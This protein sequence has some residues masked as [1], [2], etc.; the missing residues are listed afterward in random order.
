MKLSANE[1]RPR[2]ECTLQK[3]TLLCVEAKRRSQQHKHKTLKLHLTKLVN[4]YLVNN[5]MGRPYFVTYSLSHYQGLFSS[6]IKIDNNSFSY[7][8]TGG[9]VQII[10]GL[11]EL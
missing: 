10:V 6:S 5:M 8:V 11:R 9:I 1:Y 7:C 3:Q 4:I 2:L